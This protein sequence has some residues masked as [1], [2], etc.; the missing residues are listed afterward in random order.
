MGAARVGRG[1]PLSTPS[2]LLGPGCVGGTCQGDKGHAK[3]TRDRK[4]CKAEGQSQAELGAL[5]SGERAAGPHFPPGAWGDAGT[6]TPLHQP[7]RM[8]IWEV[9]DGSEWGGDI[10]G[11]VTAGVTWRPQAHVCTCVN[12]LLHMCAHT[13]LHTQPRGPARAGS[14]LFPTWLPG[15]PGVLTL[16]LGCSP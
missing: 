3:G 9:V 10:P 11:A 2:R 15:H 13:R 12:T 4:G 14:C 8:G 6:P 7:P 16:I 5:S 1:T